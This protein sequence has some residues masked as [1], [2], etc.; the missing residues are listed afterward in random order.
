[1]NL[2]PISTGR[3]ARLLGVF[4]HPD[5]E[6]FCA[7]G[8]LARW[9]ALGGEAMVLC[10]TRGE[11]GQI[12]DPTAATRATLGAVRENE[13]RAACARLGVR[14]V[15]CLDYQDGSL[16]EAGALTLAGDVA[17]RIRQFE[18]DVVVTFGPDGASGHPDH[19]AIGGATTRACWMIAR[20]GG[21]VPRLYYSAFPA[22]H[23][24]MCREMAGWLV[25]RGSRFRG[26][27][28]FVRALTLVAD[29]AALLRYAD[30]GVAVQWYPA[31]FQ[32]VEQGEAAASLYLIVSGHVEVSADDAGAGRRTV[33]RLGPGRFFGERELAGD[34]R[35]HAAVIARDTVTCLVLSARA[36]TA[37]D[38]RG[39][40]VLLASNAA[41]DGRVEPRGEA[42]V[43]DV[44]V[45]AHMEAKVGALAAHRTQFALEPA[46]LPD[47]LLGTLLGREHF[48]RV[49]V[50]HVVGY[51]VL[52]PAADAPWSDERVALALPA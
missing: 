3:P 45:S 8:T 7:G 24:L 13:L 15:E 27:A 44:D 20:E 16:E 19:I 25:S 46:M 36:P 11:A 10:A 17:E 21:R 31:G 37:F 49:A 34:E 48:A 5:D 23:H 43:F 39:E 12:Q 14:W 30:D 26:S 50:T 52:A 4:A 1:M 29:E 28:G 47:T 40:D 22:Q 35:H 6:V 18:P 33:R 41:N 2:L 42:A 32:I 51:Q 9:T 38:G